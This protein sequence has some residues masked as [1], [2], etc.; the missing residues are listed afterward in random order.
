VRGKPGWRRVEN[1]DGENLWDEWRLER[2][3][4]GWGQRERERM[5]AG[6]VGRKRAFRVGGARERVCVCWVGGA[7]KE[8]AECVWGEREREREREREGLHPKIGSN[9]IHLKLNFICILV[10]DSHKKSHNFDCLCLLNAG[11]KDVCHTA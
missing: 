7:G 11:T 5:Y 9:C 3:C 1:K 10:I 2:A 4:R 6:W 8:H